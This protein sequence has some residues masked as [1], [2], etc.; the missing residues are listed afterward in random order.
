MTALSQTIRRVTRRGPARPATPRPAP[1][2][3][4]LAPAAPVEIG[5]ND[6]L[7]VYAQ[8]AASAVDLGGLELDSPALRELRAAGVKLVVPLITRGEL[9]GTRNLG[10]RLSEQ[11]YSTDDRK[12]LDFVALHANEA[13]AVA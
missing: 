13:S 5:E 3:A 6:P 9:I 10:P 2:E 1:F 8:S 12:L 11:D 7:L 4:P